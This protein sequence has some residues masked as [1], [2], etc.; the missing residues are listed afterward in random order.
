MPETKE[1][2]PS[3]INFFQNEKELSASPALSESENLAY[4]SPAYSVHQP[5]YYQLPVMDRDISSGPGNEY[6]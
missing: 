2:E 5:L 1:V 4:S 6:R 3:L